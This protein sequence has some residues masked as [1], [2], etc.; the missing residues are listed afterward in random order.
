MKSVETG[1]LRVADALLTEAT[2]QVLP[3]LDATVARLGVLEVV[4]GRHA[5]WE[6]AEFWRLTQVGRAPAFATDPR[7]WAEK[8]LSAIRETSIPVPLA[9]AALARETLPPREQRTTGAYYTDWRLAQLLAGLA[10]P[11]VDRPGLWV[12]PACGTGVLLVAAAMAVPEGPERDAVIRDRLAGAD[13]SPK[14]L[15]GAL[16]A[17]GSL[18][19][20]LGAV[21]GFASRLRVQD[22]LRSAAAWARLAPNGVALVIANP[23]WEKLTVSRHEIAQGSG[24]DRHYGQSFAEE[25]DLTGPKRDLLR[26]IEQVAAG[27]RL[28]GKGGHDLY[29]LFLELGIGLAAE[30]GVLALLVPAGLIRAQGTETLRKELDAAATELSI[31]VIENRARNFAIDTRFKFLALVASIGAGPRGPISL[32]V[33]DRTGDLPADAVAIDRAELLD[34]RPDLSLPE[35]RTETEWA[36]FARLTRAAVTVGDKEGPWRPA[37]KREIDMTLDADTFLRTPHAGTVPLLEGRHV[38]NF[39]ARAKSYLGGEGRAA[40]WRP[41][42]LRSAPANAVTQWF[43][44]R[45]TLRADA[46][47]RV[48]R[49][50][51]GFCDITGQTNERTMLAA[52]IP[53]GYV[54]GNKIPTLLFPDGGADREDLFLALANSFVVDWM[55][56]R[57]VTTTVN[58]FL[59]ET[60]P[61]PQVDQDSPTG[62][63]LIDLTRKIT[64][65]EGDRTA[66]AWGVGLRRARVDALV[67]SAWGLSPADMELVMRDF[68]L[69]DRGQSPLVG[70]HTSTV[71]RDVVL[72]ALAAEL[73]ADHPSVRRTEQ[74]HRK[75]AVPYIGAEYV[76]RKK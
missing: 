18:T 63:E 32:R 57:V 35:V 43:V 53:A 69:L 55:L 73:D 19:S 30:D 7:G 40:L 33:A 59:L 12:D 5:D 22:S 61:M 8:V 34:V 37:Y 11:T 25:I 27:T 6:A 41:E 50:R 3:G 26:Y 67:A 64:A 9:L 13:L 23:P 75:G 16:L 66:D 14:A 45:A 10:V 1:L 58:L 31:S 2:G 15:R 71:T 70:E 20:D 46:A 54:C 47:A 4:A 38:T 76:Q 17:V 44:P 56:R 65:A 62:R 28:Q 48:E 49:S 52:R 72:A 74:A 60:L 39:R 51:V 36:L 24:T 68:P 29:K 42:Q 21:V